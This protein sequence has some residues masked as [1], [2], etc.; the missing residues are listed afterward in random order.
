MQTEQEL[1]EL[2]DKPQSPRKTQIIFVIFALSAVAAI[3][4][5]Y[6]KLFPVEASPAVAPVTRQLDNTPELRSSAAPTTITNLKLSPV[7]DAT[8]GLSIELP[9]GWSSSTTSGALIAIADSCGTTG[10]LEYPFIYTSDTDVINEMNVYLNSLKIDLKRGETITTSTPTTLNNQTTALFSGSL[11][12]NEIVGSATTS[13]MN[14]TGLVTISW[15]P[16][17][18]KTELETTINS[19]RQSFTVTKEAPYFQPVGNSLR[20]G[21]PLNW[22]AED[23]DQRIRIS[24]NEGGFIT[25]ALLQRTEE[26][27][28]SD[29]FDTWIQ[30]E[31]NAQQLDNQ[32]M[33]NEEQP[34]AYID[35]DERTWEITSREIT[36]E[37]D[38]QTMHA[39]LLA[40]TTD[41]LGRNVILTWRAAPEKTWRNLESALISVER[42]LVIPI[43]TDDTV[44]NTETDL[45]TKDKS[46]TLPVWIPSKT[47]TPFSSA[48]VIRERHKSPKTFWSDRIFAVTSARATDG[49]AYL[50]PLLNYN[51]ETQRYKLNENNL[52]TTL[53]EE[54]GGLWNQNQNK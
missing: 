27:Q 32:Q 21:K 18:K 33:L 40:G 49:T 16:K 9:N 46:L 41:V 13:A 6:H 11:C 39:I 52:S 30:L 47:Q 1:Q 34:F 38:G 2:L 54:Q 17:D 4:L 7:K 14:G 44:L 8:T 53:I 29:I 10:I 43:A 19:I 23:S 28:L 25:A 15:S 22:K 42:T 48:G 35:R 12:N 26:S 37:Q 51:S 50:A 3:P 45:T 20:I 24:N 31:N 5:F 36:Y